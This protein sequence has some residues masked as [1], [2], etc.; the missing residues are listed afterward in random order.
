MLIYRPYKFLVQAVIQE[1][2]DDGNVVRELTA[3]QPQPVFGIDGLHRYADTFELDLA[4]ST[5]REARP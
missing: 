5:P 4:T 2:D 1:L 3:E